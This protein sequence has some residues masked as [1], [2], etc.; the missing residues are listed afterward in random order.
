MKIVELW[1]ATRNSAGVKPF[2]VRVENGVVTG[3]GDGYWKF[4]PV[5]PLEAFQRFWPSVCETQE[6]AL[7]EYRTIE[8]ERIQKAQAALAA[9]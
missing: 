8:M 9:L 6:M 4:Y 5:M 1:Q 7:A 3:S 2:P